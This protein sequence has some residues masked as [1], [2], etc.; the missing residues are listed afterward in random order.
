MIT[1]H[2][3]SVLPIAIEK[4]IP[5]MGQSKESQMPSHV[6][7]TQLASRVLTESQEDDLHCEL[8]FEHSAESR[9]KSYLGIVEHK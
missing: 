3:P 8:C 6:N 1:E 7:G 5:C 4:S 9:A 2:L